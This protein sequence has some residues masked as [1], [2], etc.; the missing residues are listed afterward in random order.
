MVRLLKNL[1]NPVSLFTAVASASL[2]TILVI[3]AL[4][5]NRPPSGALP[6]PSAVVTVLPAFTPT[7]IPGSPT[8][9][10]GEANL[11]PTV[12]AAPGNLS[13]GAVVQITDTGGKGLNLR[14]SPGLNSSVLYL[15]LEAEVFEIR[16]GPVEADGFTWWYLA[17]FYDETR[18]GW[19]AANFLEVVLDP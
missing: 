10:S 9:D 13:L 19:G 1:F 3:G 11:T 6:L 16:D 12:P 5:I 18:N 4:S 7:A 14:S 8:P 17:G 15:G 2:L